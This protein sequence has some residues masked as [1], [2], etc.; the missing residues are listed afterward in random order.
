[1]KESADVFAR[2]L[3]LDAGPLVAAID[4]SD[5][6]HRWARQTLPKLRGRAITCEPCVTEALHLLE[7]APRAI[8][9]LRGFLERIEIV[10]VL[11]TQLAEVFDELENF[12]PSM[13]LAD[14]CL[15]VLQRRISGSIVITT[16][17]RD[18]STYR[19]P[20]LSPKGVFTA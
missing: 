11:P 20:F 6:H 19:V 9:A 16:D 18:F 14:G 12:A 8:E 7:N 5:E 17:H 2:T 1:M 3:L 15:V 10:P 4:R 13:D